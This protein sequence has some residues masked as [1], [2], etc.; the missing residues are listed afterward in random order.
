MFPTVMNSLSVGV[1]SVAKES[2]RT[3]HLCGERFS[4]VDWTTK[5]SF[6]RRS[7]NFGNVS[8]FSSTSRGNKHIFRAYPSTLKIAKLCF[9]TTAAHSTIIWSAR[10]GFL[11]LREAGTGF[12][13][14]LPLPSTHVWSSRKHHIVHGNNAQ[15][16][17]RYSLAK[18]ITG[19]IKFTKRTELWL[20]FW[21]LDDIFEPPGQNEIIIL[22]TDSRFFFSLASP[23][24]RIRACEAQ[25]LALTLLWPYSKPILEKKPDCFAVYLETGHVNLHVI[26]WDQALF[27][28]FCFFA[29]LAR[30]GKK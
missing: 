15:D 6:I 26:T 24:L 5:S 11:L 22:K 12:V 17:F 13:G 1:C 8:P 10:L 27:F 2:Q 29:S 20:D 16:C 9:E 23:A 25:A 4:F 3:F 7:A 30:E 19:C 21:Q 28:F 14:V 18:S